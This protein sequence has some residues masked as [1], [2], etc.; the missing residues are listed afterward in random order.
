MFIGWE[1]SKFWHKP[2][3]SHVE[4]PKE[5]TEKINQL[6]CESFSSTARITELSY[7]LQAKELIDHMLKL[8]LG[9]FNSLKNG[10]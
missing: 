6:V 2:D 9:K 7:E 10:P 3:Y 4:Y 1:V 5:I 8:L